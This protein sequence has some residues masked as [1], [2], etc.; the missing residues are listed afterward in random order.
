MNKRLR[1]KAKR[2][3]VFNRRKC[4]CSLRLPVVRYFFADETEQLSGLDIE[5]IRESSPGVI[6]HWGRP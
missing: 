6:S 3:K 2:K 5:K 4:T 1:K